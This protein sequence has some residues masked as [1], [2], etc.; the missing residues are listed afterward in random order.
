LDEIKSLKNFTMMHK[1]PYT[2]LSLILI[3]NL[4]A[5]AHVELTYPEGGETLYSGD[6]ITITWVQVQAH[7]VQ[8]W[9][10]YYSPD[11]AETW[12]TISNNIAADLREYDW[13]VPEEETS[14]GRIRVV[15]N[16]TDTDF[17][18]VSTNLKVVQITGI[19]ES[20]NTLSV[21]SL[22]SYPNPFRQETKISFTIYKKDFVMLEIFQLN[23]KKVTT[24]I[25]QTLSPDDYVIDWIPEN[26]AS[27]TYFAILMVGNK[28]KTFKL[29]QL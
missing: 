6:T 18:D 8:N 15:Q 24:L 21:Q 5:N 11:G 27:E 1:L 17:E 12:Q 22:S 16:N 19:E 28:R 26:I 2:I 20:R 9:E 13:I 10:L 3:I 7:D 25:Q 14:T 23:G 29:Q 4:A